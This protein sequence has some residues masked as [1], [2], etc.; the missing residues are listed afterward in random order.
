M[1]TQTQKATR[2]ATKK[3]AAPEAKKPAAP[4][5]DPSILAIHINTTGRVCLGKAATARINGLG[6]MLIT[7]DGTTVRMLPRK[8]P[9]TTRWKFA[10]PM[11]APMSAPR[12][13]LSSSASMA[14]RPTI[15]RPNR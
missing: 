14:P 1:K 10:E 8:R 11:A 5:A 4:K 9:P 3:A 2:T 6:H 13:C 15:S 12:A 7:A